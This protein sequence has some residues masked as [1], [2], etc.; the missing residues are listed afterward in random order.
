MPTH[1]G[2]SSR[3]LQLVEISVEAPGIEQDSPYPPEGRS[4]L[5]PDKV[6]GQGGRFHLQ[7]STARDPRWRNRKPLRA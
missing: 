1:R 6:L 2:E 4:K 3:E 7:N 5:P